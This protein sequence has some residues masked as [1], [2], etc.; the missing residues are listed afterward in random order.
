MNNATFLVVYATCPFNLLHQKTAGLWGCGHTKQ[1][2]R[3]LAGLLGKNGDTL[4]SLREPAGY[5]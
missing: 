2:A 5:C 1:K 3:Q 4:E